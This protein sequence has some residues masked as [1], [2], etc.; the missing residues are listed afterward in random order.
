MNQLTDQQIAQYLDV[1]FQTAS[2]QAGRMAG[3]NPRIEAA[4][5]A[6]I[7][8]YEDEVNLID[9]KEWPAIIAEHEKNGW[10]QRQLITY[11]HDQNGEPSCVTNA[12]CGA[13]EIK[14]AV[15]YGVENVTLLSPIS[16]YK[17]VGSPRS[18]SSLTANMKRFLEIGVLPLDTPENKAKFKHTHPHNGYSKSLPSGFEETA[19][20]FRNAEWLDINGWKPFVS[21]LLSGHPVIYARS[22][23][24]ILAVSLQHKNGVYILDYL[25]SW[26]PWGNPV[27][28]KFNAGLG[29]DSERVAKSAC[30]GSMALRTVKLIT[31]P[32]IAL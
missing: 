20:L 13:H 11:V 26:G 22:G 8:L 19:S 5:A 7:P 4:G 18:G 6:G 30:Y 24:C 21:A 16:G 17:F 27:N 23:H 3:M 32:A 10:P 14:Q 2:V 29:H 1:D 15:T 28:D 12:F 31:P 25:N 9:E